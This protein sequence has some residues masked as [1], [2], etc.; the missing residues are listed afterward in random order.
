M[1]EDGSVFGDENSR[2]DGEGKHLECDE[3]ALPPWKHWFENAAFVEAMECR[4][5]VLQLTSR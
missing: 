5:V 3:C 2:H 4:A 1:L